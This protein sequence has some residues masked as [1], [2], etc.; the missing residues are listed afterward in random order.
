MG[1]SRRHA[2]KLVAS[3]PTRE[4]AR[5]L[6][7]K[8]KPRQGLFLLAVGVVLPQVVSGTFPD[9]SEFCREILYLN[10][11]EELIFSQAPYTLGVFYIPPTPTSDNRT[12]KFRESRKEK[13]FSA[14]NTTSRVKACYPVLHK[15]TKDNSPKEEGAVRAHLLQFYCNARPIN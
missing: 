4:H 1:F 7:K 11:L 3:N 8:I 6:H 14:T 2:C 9:N 12:G 10:H 5:S 13:E 15:H